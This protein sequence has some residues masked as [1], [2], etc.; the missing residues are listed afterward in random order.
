MGSGTTAVACLKLNRRFVGVERSE[1]YVE[2]ANK[3]IESYLKQK[4]VDDFSG[5]GE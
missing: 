5:L 4:K 3:R 1:Q 2:I